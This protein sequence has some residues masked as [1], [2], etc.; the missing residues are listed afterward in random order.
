M[1][2]RIALALVPAACIPLALCACPSTLP[3]EPPYVVFPPYDAA[4]AEGSAATCAPDPICRVACENL[5]KMGCPEAEPAG[6]TCECVCTAA[7]AN[8]L[9]LDPIC[10]ANASTPD[11]ARAC[12]VRCAGR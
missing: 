9:R 7:K 1:K 5:A 4:P 11:Q 12:G 10:A 3:P 8:G 2:S 6:M